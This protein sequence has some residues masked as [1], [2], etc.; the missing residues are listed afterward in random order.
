MSHIEHRK[1]RSRTATEAAGTG[2]DL[3][4]QWIAALLLYTYSDAGVAVGFQEVQD[5]VA[6]VAVGFQEVED[7]VAG[8]EARL[9]VS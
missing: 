4:C 9:H 3:L 1:Y 2:C 7:S 6:G 5:S 8:V